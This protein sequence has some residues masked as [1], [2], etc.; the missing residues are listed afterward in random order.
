MLVL[1]VDPDGVALA[2]R[3]AARILTREAHLIAFAE[4]R[5]EGEAFGGRPV[6]YLGIV[7]VREHRG[8]GVDHAA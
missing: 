6:E 8:A 7:L 3:P 2:E 1:L 5:A 4:E